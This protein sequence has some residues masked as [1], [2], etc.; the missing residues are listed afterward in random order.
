MSR[1]YIVGGTVPSHTCAVENR[2]YVPIPDRRRNSP[3]SVEQDRLILL[4]S[5]YQAVGG[6]SMYGIPYRNHAAWEVG[7][8]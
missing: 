2:A 3:H 8:P 5:R 6:T 4:G 1:Y 7:T